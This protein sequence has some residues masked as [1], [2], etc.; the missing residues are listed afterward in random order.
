MLRAYLS[1]PIRGPK[2]STATQEDM[3]TNNQAAIKFA[4]T[5]RQ[6]FPALDLYVPAEHDEALNILWRENYITID[7]LLWADC[8]VLAKRDFLIAYVPYGFVS[9]GMSK[10]INYAQKHNIPYHVLAGDNDEMHTLAHFIET[11]FLKR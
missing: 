4:N 9:S 5:I 2:G 7:E 3:D 10:E 1:H 11:H 6:H 8:R